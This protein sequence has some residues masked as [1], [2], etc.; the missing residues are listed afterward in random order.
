M[1]EVGRIHKIGQCVRGTCRVHGPE[2]KL[3]VNLSMQVAVGAGVN[4][5]SVRSLAHAAVQ[6]VHWFASGAAAGVDRQAMHKL[7]RGAIHVKTALHGFG[8]LAKSPT[9]FRHF[10]GVIQVTLRGQMTFLQCV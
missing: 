4:R 9:S 8:P 3:M 1:M 10:H 2:C 6:M 5:R 7:F